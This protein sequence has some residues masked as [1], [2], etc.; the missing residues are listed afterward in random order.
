MRRRARPSRWWTPWARRARAFSALRRRI[1]SRPA[2]SMASPS[3]L[4]GKPSAR[5][6][7]AALEQ[8]YA[9]CEQVRVVPS[10][11]GSKQTQHLEPEALNETDD[12]ELRV[13]GNEAHRH[14]L[15]VARLDNLGKGASGA[16]VQN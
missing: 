13:F 9:D 10:A 8:R 4:P 16:A 5:A 2:G 3:A 11:G 12:L 7:E 15:L 1:G 14:A 6:L